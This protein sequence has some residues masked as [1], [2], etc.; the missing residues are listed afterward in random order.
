MIKFKYNS[1][2]HGKMAIH[3]EPPV[4]IN[5]G[6]ERFDR[7]R[8][9]VNTGLFVALAPENHF[10]IV[11]LGETCTHMSVID[12]A[13]ERGI[14]GIVL[15]GGTID[16][17]DKD[18]SVSVR[19]YSQSFGSLPNE[20]LIEYFSSFGY[21]VKATMLYGDKNKEEFE[22]FKRLDISTP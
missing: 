10:Q 5:F 20:V 21:R 1:T 16:F 15:G 3:Y 14:G 12:A 22:W 6:G 9:R 18:K 2:I 19:G 7:R 11:A 4:F 13:Q 8:G 17:F